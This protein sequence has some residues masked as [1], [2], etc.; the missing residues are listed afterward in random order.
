MW[1]YYGYEHPM[2]WGGGFGIVGALFSIIWIVILIAVIIALVRYFRGKPMR[3]QGSDRA[4][5]I[6]K[7]RYAKGEIDTEEFEE[8]KKALSS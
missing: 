3:W 6:L 7:E 2:M 1:G 5:D 8:K 4:L